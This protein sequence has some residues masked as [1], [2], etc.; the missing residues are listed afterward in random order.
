VTSAEIEQAVSEAHRR[1]WAR[2]LST[3]VRLTRDIDL[4]EDAVQDA[5]AV[6]LEAWP[7]DVVPNSPAAWLTTVARRKALDLLRRDQTLARKLPL[8]IVPDSDD[9]GL[10]VPEDIQ[11]DRLRLI[12]TCC[13]PALALES[14]VPLTLRLVCG[15]ATPEIAHLLLIPEPTVA[16]RIT[17][18]K[19]KIRSAG[20]PYQAPGE[21]DLP[22]RL[23]AV[24]AVVYLV[25]TE[26]HT[27]SRGGDLTRPKHVEQ[28]TELARLL[29]ELMPEQA[30]VL[31]LLALM[32][33][34][35]ARRA[36]R[37][38]AAGQIVLLEDQDRARW[39]RGAITEGVALV[40]RAFQAARPRG[41]G[42][43]ALQA[44]I[45]AVHAEAPSYEATDWAQVLAL[46]DALLA[47][48]PSPVA[49]LSRTVAYARIH[50]PAAG[51]AEVDRLAEDPRLAGYHLLPAAR[52]EFLRQ[53]GDG[54]QAAA[55]YLEAARLTDNE[56]EQ[57]FLR[58][59]AARVSAS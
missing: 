23:P 29:L 14:Q 33:L 31:G 9:G 50:G 18:A 27:A 16:A 6:A 4:A 47:I 54:Q 40:E 22:E 58:A 51:L 55:A 52:A 3:V 43:Y 56:V 44:A 1:D 17:R 5:F 38:D 7:R 30:E 46:Y 2:V 42:P 10:E 49:A 20:I 41:P 25:F 57:G 8:L 13:H 26:G 21:R 24:L 48:H 12:F 39:D 11:D 59:R 34:T 53:L 28:A 15:L 35:D 37:L 19:K 32:R 45:A 36:S